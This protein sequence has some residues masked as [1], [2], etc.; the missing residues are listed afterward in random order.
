[1]EE[2]VRPLLARSGLCV[3]YAHYI[4]RLTFIYNR[5]SPSRQTEALINSKSMSKQS[6][7]VHL[8]DWTEK[9]VG[10][11]FP[12]LYSWMCSPPDPPNEAE[13]HT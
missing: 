8:G 3:R 12:Q 4:D 11:V 5:S 7:M 9:N 10:L 13:A 1:M 6:L 2:L